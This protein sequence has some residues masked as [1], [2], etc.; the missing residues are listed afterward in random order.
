MRRGL[1]AVEATEGGK[2]TD[3]FRR[4]RDETRRRPAGAAAD[5]LAADA[6]AW[7]D[8]ADAVRRIAA[9]RR[10]PAQADRPQGQQG[11]TGSTPIAAAAAP[12]VAALQRGVAVEV[13]ADNA[14]LLRHGLRAID[15][16]GELKRRDRVLDFQ[17]L[18]YLALRLLTDDAVRAQVHQRLDARLDHLLLDE[19]QDTNR[20]QWDLLTP[21]LEEMLAGGDP[22]RTG[23]VVGDV[24]QAI[25]GFRGADATIFAEAAAPGRGAR[26]A[27]LLELPTNFRSLPAV[28]A[29]VGTLF[30]H[31]PLR[32]LLGSDVAPGRPPARR[33]RPTAAARWCWSSRS[34]TTT[35]PPPTRR[36]RTPWSAWCGDSRPRATTSATSWCSAGAR[37]TSPS[38]RWRCAARGIP[39]VPAGRGLL[40]RSREVQ[41]LLALLRWLTFPA[42][43]VAG[44][45]VLRSPLVRLP[46]T[47][48]QELLAAR[49]AAP[50]RRRRTLWDVACRIG[51]TSR[52]SPR[53]LRDWHQ[54]AGL[55]PLHDLL[56]RIYRT[57]DVLARMEIAF[58]EQ[59]RFNLLRLTDVA[60]AVEA[61]GG[62]GARPGR[63]AG[64]RRRRRRRG[65]RRA[66]ARR[67]AAACA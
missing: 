20:N 60:L 14:R 38:T 44:A 6:A 33:A 65:G 34:R 2:P 55:D 64:P 49:L 66:A 50:G 58:G 31:E 61:A 40:A 57:G 59:A 45:A 15:L 46:E 24:K 67:G 54:H 19:F 43:D 29:T 10:R 30:Q 42:D 25:Y 32:S 12:V 27:T 48:V 8:V 18:E 51:R 21:L 5:R 4:W 63:R 13:L 3:G 53:R 22:P 62:F 56:R 35:P 26:A 23:F 17:D 7:P 37:R 1:A 11:R 47:A 9:D 28:V 16:Y 39:L 41:D 36:R 52:R